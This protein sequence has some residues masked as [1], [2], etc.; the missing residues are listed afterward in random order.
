MVCYG[1]LADEIG[2]EQPFY[3]LQSLAPNSCPDSSVMIERMA[4]LYNQEVRRVQPMG[5]IF[6]EDGRWEG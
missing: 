6:W 1:E 2:V 5:P 4:E 3:G